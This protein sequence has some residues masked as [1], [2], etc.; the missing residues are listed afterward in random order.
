MSPLAHE[1]RTYR[2]RM[3]RPGLVGF[4]VAVKETDLWVLAAR[5]FSSEVRD[6]VIQ[7]RQQLEAYIAANPDFLTTLA[8]GPPTPSP[9]RWSGR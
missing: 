9:R 6:L 3:A 4:Q 7:E 8:P 5:D 1:P 2:T